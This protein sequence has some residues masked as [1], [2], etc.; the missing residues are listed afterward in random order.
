MMSPA[1]DYTRYIISNKNKGMALSEAQKEERAA[2]RMK[3]TEREM[4]QMETMHEK[5]V[6]N[7]AKN[8]AWEK[9]LAA[10]KSKRNQELKELK[11]MR[12][13]A[14]VL[15]G[16]ESLNPTLLTAE[17]KELLSNNDWF[18]KAQDIANK[19]QNERGMNEEIRK[20]IAE[21][22]EEQEKKEK[23]NNCDK[24]QSSY[25]KYELFSFIFND[26]YFFL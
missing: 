17:Q 5:S 25:Q 16:L 14:E 19:H 22:Y 23:V 11:D 13:Q 12:K 20:I 18:V 4:H 3:A 1:Y 26:I 21:Y 2:L 8:A 10:S 7:D 15:R 6:A 9:S 24:K